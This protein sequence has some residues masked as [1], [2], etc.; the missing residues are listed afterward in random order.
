MKYLIFIIFL[1][2]PTLAFAQQFLCISEK[3]SG[4]KYLGN[5]WKSVPFK[6]DN[7]YLVNLDNNTVSRFG[8]SEPIHR[9]C[10]NFRMHG[11]QLFDCGENF[12]EF[13]MSKDTLKYLITWPYIDYVIDDTTGT[14]NIELGTCTKF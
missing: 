12:G 1:Q 6:V 8:E 2:T 9:N 13:T 14:P 7:K 11:Q 3:A 10:S 4:F 5:E